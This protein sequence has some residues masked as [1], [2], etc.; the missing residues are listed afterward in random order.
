M[1][2]GRKNGNRFDRVRN[3]S[4]LRANREERAGVVFKA[5]RKVNVDDADTI[6]GVLW[7][8][9][10]EGEIPPLNMSCDINT[11]VFDPYRMSQREG[12]GRLSA[13]QLGR[14]IADISAN[15]TL[16]KPEH[17]MSIARYE[18]SENGRMLI[19][20]FESDVLAEERAEI[21]Q[22]LG[23]NG[24]NGFSR[25]GRRN[26]RDRVASPNFIAGR[27]YS[28]VPRQDRASVA[29]DAIQELIV[30][31]LGSANIRLGE[32][33]VTSPSAH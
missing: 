33:E 26:G 3:R 15:D 30:K 18:V 8:L 21:Y 10:N 20:R 11:Y 9:M 14:V 1:P 5:W 31:A 27:F 2:M 24:V 29:D 19:G 16:A 23:K 4:D 17:D 7:D 12:E 22:I 13:Q 6:V 32:L 25:S 28:P